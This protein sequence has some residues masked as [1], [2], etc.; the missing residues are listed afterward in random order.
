MA[1]MAG[2]GG[3]SSL[4]LR[5]FRMGSSVTGGEGVPGFT[6]LGGGAAG[7]ERGVNFAGRGCLEGV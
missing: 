3:P 7:G 4:A 2:S 1:M 5:G 6:H